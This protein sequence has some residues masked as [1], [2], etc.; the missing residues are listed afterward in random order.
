MT[1]INWTN[2]RV[3][4]S[5]LIP[6]ESNPKTSTGKQQA[7]LTN[8]FEELGQFQTIA[9]GPAGEVYDGHQRLSALKAKH[10]AGYEVEA[11]QASRPLTDEERRKIAIYS[12]QIGAWDWDIL[13]SWNPDELQEWGFDK[14]L[15]KDWGADYSNLA[16]FLGAEDVPD[17]QPTDADDQ[18]RL[19]QKSP[20]ICP[21]CGE[22]FIPA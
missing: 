13:S 11:R 18:P 7:Q 9:I 19:D 17:F 10:G 21:H 3:K 5:A 15:L 14:D 16:A 20:V 4:L 8:S 1:D 12:R 6:W 22:E 2:T